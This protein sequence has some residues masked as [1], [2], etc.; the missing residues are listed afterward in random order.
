MKRSIL[1]MLMP[2][3]VVVVAG[4]SSNTVHLSREEFDRL[5][6]DSRQEIFDAENDLVIA[7][8][9]ADDAVEKKQAAER[10]L[11]ELDQRLKRATGRLTG[12]GKAARIEQVRQVF[13]KH[14][15]YVNAQIDV[16]S[17]TIRTSALQTSLSRARLQLTRLRQLARVGRV[18]DSSLKPFEDAVAALEKRVKDASK[19]ETDLRAK[20]Q[21]QLDGWKSAEDSYA[22]AA[23]D[24]DTGIW[25]E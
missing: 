24:Y 5:P 18:T 25:E 22:R 14:R 6:R 3:A 21:T 10:S 17:A 2:L 4:C 12:S 16:A 9:Q 23:G 7:R 8:D 15:G 1:S 19:S 11:G 20:A 13:A